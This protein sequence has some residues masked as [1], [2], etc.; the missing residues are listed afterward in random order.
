ME[1]MNSRLIVSCSISKIK[2]FPVFTA[3]V[4][5]ISVQYFGYVFSKGSYN[6]LSNVL[7]IKTL[8]HLLFNVLAF[9]K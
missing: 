8:Y 2:D 9:G 5:E 4:K 6:F 3:I 7:Q 1:A